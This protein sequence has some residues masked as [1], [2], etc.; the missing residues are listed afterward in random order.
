M[1]Y[2]FKNFSIKANSKEEV[3]A[4][5][6]F[7]K[8]LNKRMT[9][10][11]NEPAA[12]F[13]FKIDETIENKDDFVIS[14]NNGQIVIFAKTVRGL[15][16]GYS[17]FLRK[18][19]FSNNTLTLIKNIS[20]TYTPQKKIRGHQTGYRPLPNTYDAWSYEQ[21]KQYFLDMMAFGANTCEHT[22]LKETDKNGLMKYNPYEF[23]VETSKIADEI[24]LAVSL[25]QPNDEKETEENELKA[26]DELYSEI[27]RIDIIFPPGG[28]PGKL[29]ADVFVD[30]CKKIKDIAKKYHPNIEM[31][32][33]AQAPHGAENWGEMFVDGVN[34][35]TDSIDTVIMGPNHAYPMHELRKR[36]DE[37]IPM[38]F[39][40]DITHNLRCEY[41]VNFLKDDWH[42]SFA[43]TLSR[44]SVNPRPTEIRTLHR[45]FSPY[46]IGSVSYSEGVHDDLNKA[47]WG[48]LEWDMNTP[49]REII[50]DYC[51]YF[52]YGADAEKIT[53][54]IFLLEKNWQGAPEENPCIDICYTNMCEL[55]KDYPVL[56]ENWRFLNLYFRA[57]CD[58]IIKLK[59]IFESEL[60]ERAEEKLLENDIS[61]AADILKTSYSKEYT[62]LRNSLF[63]Q[64]QKLF[65]LIGIQLDI[66]HFF[67]DGWERGAVLETID[68]NVTDRAYL[69]SKLEYAQTLDGDAKFDYI[70]RL[71]SLRKNNPNEIY[72]SVAL[73]NLDT[74][75]TS[76]N[77]EYYMDVQGDRPERQNP[78]IPMG[79]AKLYDHYSFKAKFGGFKAD[80]DY[81]LR[82]AYKPNPCEKV[83]NYKVTANNTVIYEGAQYGGH[84]DETFSE[85][86]LVPGFET[87]VYDLPKKVFINGTLELE[88]SEPI[89]GFKFCELWI[90]P[91]K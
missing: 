91:K 29:P 42:F 89:V 36:I 44:E 58:K 20:G 24:D 14:Q 41:P 88:I 72:Y 31:H 83:K 51:R 73:H 2:T 86:M 61:S 62:E 18:S 19:V 56:N 53:D 22:V 34:S 70:K 81:T 79:M 7:L 21:Y 32:P 38:R 76:Q 35:S 47:V 90:K 78:P 25:W 26:R 80:T 3:T 49:L 4:K 74:L 39:Y 23:L 16:F 69:L 40:P 66:E 75:G 43:N 27:P 28:D 55:L 8:E 77:G 82:I 68:N 71:L 9:M 84:S 59:R 46:T 50:S 11:K 6:F 17:L 10:Q 33:S 57:T 48:A 15:I 65:D 54:C 1:R 5:E 87:L 45:L 63:T 12:A 67:A 64:A 37:K 60:I 30:R 13:E 52:M 85:E